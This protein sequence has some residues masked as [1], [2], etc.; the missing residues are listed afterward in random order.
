LERNPADAVELAAPQNVTADVGRLELVSADDRHGPV[1]AGKVA[2]AVPVIEVIVD[3]DYGPV[4][5]AQRAPADIIV[6]PPP[7]NPSGPPDIV[8]DPIPA[9]AEPPVP[10]AVVIDRPAPGLGGDPVPAE[11]DVPGPVAVQ[12]R[13]PVVIDPVGDPDVPIGLFVGP[14]AVLVELLFIVSEV[15]WQVA[16]GAPLGKQG[17]PGRVPLVERVRARVVVVGIADEPSVRGDER[18]PAANDDR[19]L[20]S[21]GLEAA[22]KDDELGL[23][24]DAHVEPV[25]A[26][27]QD[28]AGRVGSMDLDRLVA[29]ERADPQISAPFENMDLD[30]LIPL[31]GQEGEF[32]LGVVIEPQVVPAAEVDFGLSHACPELVSAD[33]GQ[34]DLGLFGAG[35][36]G[37][38][39]EDVPADIGQA[40][41][42]RGIIAL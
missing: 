42:A 36:R 27:L 15:G 17:V 2:V 25:E 5:P 13:P 21:G 33:Q 10:A 9:E 6:V 32:N 40:G 18:L 41:K 11:A 14:V 30:P 34:V 24:V 35:V 16:G 37:P 26:F 39:D 31:N 12:I 23:T 8:G 1:V 22:F 20:L 29:G 7:V 28:V 3:D 19:A 38:L 4:V